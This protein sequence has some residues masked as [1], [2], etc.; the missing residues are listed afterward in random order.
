M[1]I[2]PLIDRWQTDEGK[3]YKGTLIDMDAYNADPRDPG[4]MCAQGQVLHH[5]GWDA[6]SLHHVEQDYADS[7]VARL[8]N[9]SEAHAVLL[10]IVNDRADGA[11]AVVLTDPGA[12]LG[13][14]WSK[15]LD[16]W[17]PLDTMTKAAWEDAQAAEWEAAWEDAQA[18]EWEASWEIAQAAAGVA[19]LEA[20]GG[21]ALAVALAVAQAAAQAASL[22]DA[23][24]ATWEIQGAEIMRRE[25]RP[26]YFL[27]IFGFASPD[28]I[29]ARPADY[30]PFRA[31]KNP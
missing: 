31:S 15:V 2:Q 16:F 28:D 7:E 1:N 11:P 21:A 8:L 10:R 23:Q 14:Q 25:G 3:P 30:G 19:A 12:V 6:Y 13:G 20:A 27:P 22:P 24:A 17:W 26:F 4:C 29:P 5:A 18:A 9:I